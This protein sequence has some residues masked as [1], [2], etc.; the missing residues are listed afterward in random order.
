MA[1]TYTITA[2]QRA[3]LQALIDSDNRVAFYLQLNEYTGSKSALLMAQI[4]SS[5]GVVGG[6]AW[7]INGAYALGLPGYPSGGVG[8]F[9]RL[10]AAQDIDSIKIAENGSGL[11]VVPGDQQMLLGAFA[12]LMVPTSINAVWTTM[13]KSIARKTVKLGLRFTCLK[14]LTCQQPIRE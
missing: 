12:W 1:D 2:V 13:A 4:S 10:I 5:S 6:T 14:A 3:T 7:A 9:S 8:E 11:Y